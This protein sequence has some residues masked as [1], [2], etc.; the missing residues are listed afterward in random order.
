MTK[1]TEL[2]VGAA[3]GGFVGQLLGGS[4]AAFFVGV[5]NPMSAVG[6]SSAM[7][8]VTWVHAVAPLAGLAGGFLLVRSAQQRRAAAGSATLRGDQE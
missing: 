4:A 2:L 8:I 6:G 7:T 5:G 3:C 1:N